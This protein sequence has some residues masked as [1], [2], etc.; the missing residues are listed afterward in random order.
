[1]DKKKKNNI[2][3]IHFAFVPGISASSKFIH[4]RKYKEKLAKIK[5]IQSE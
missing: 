5:S 4:S 3:F 1:M 2:Q